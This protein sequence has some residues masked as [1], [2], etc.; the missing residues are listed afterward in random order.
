MA[1]RGHPDVAVTVHVDQIPGGTLAELRLGQKLRAIDCGHL[2]RSE[3][4]GPGEAMNQLAARGGRIEIEA[5]EQLEE[6][7]Q[8]LAF[9][10]DVGA[11]TQI[12]FG[13]IAD[14]RARGDDPR[15]GVMCRG[16]HLA[17]RAAHPGQAHFAQEV[18][19]VLVQ[20][21]HLRPNRL[22]LAAVRAEILGEA[23]R[24]EIADIVEAKV[25]LFVFV[26]VREGWGD[27]PERYR[28]MGLEFPKE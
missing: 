27:D 5:T 23:A 12:R 10:S 16:D 20:H 26:K 1:V 8:P 4:C 15:P 21:D 14:V 3:D 11:G 18:E 24:K 2:P 7:G 28:A 9:E 17:G 6:G 19:I 25:H 13:R 22:Q